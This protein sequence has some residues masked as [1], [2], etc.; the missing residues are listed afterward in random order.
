MAVNI[1]RDTRRRVP[2]FYVPE[3]CRRRR[4]MNKA[5]ARTT[6]QTAIKDRIVAH[7]I[8]EVRNPDR[9][10][11]RASKRKD[12]SGHCPLSRNTKPGELLEN[13]RPERI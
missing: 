1:W 6:R 11:V 10:K 8:I 12:I 5:M 7:I 2:N 4:F 3:A 9:L 13:S